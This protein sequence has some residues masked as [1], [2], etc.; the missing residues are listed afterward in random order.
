MTVT[1]VLAGPAAPTPTT[2]PPRPL[3][4]PR[5]R[6]FRRWVSPLVILTL[7]QLASSTGLL[8]PRKMAS[9][10]EIAVR[11][12][13]LIS[14]GTLGPAVLA[15]L[16][17]VGLGFAI[18]AVIGVGLALVA[19][20]SRLGDDAVDPP[21]QMLRTLPHLGLVPLFI[22]WMGLGDTPKVV[23]IAMGVLFPLYLNTLGG[24]RSIDRKTMEVA[25]ALHLTRMQRIRHVVLPGAM[26]QALVGLRQSLGIA[27]LTLIVAETISA[28]SGLGFM[29]NNAREFLQMDVIV[30]GLVTYS[31]LGLLTDVAVRHLE[32]RAL[33]WRS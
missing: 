7:W 2:P 3:Q 29:I 13:E 32:R 24:I 8:D 31:L 10:V 17:R 19:G 5:L 25:K 12:V 15:S 33:S 27:W 16:E 6:H 4:R 1:P 26:P 30:V 11:S 28:T 14:D 22:A 23:L 18:G 20:L 9:P 21:L